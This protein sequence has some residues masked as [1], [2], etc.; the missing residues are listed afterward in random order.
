MRVVQ[1]SDLHLSPTHGFFVANWRKTVA[2]VEALSPDLVIISG[3]LA[4]N[5]PEENDELAFARTEL[6]PLR[7]P[8]RVLPGNHD[9]GD[10]PPGQ[11]AHQIVDAPRLER[12]RAVFQDDWW[13]V[14]TAEWRIVGLNAQLFGSGLADEA[15]Q[16][17]WLDA[18]LSAPDARD[19]AVFLHKPLYVDGI[20][21]AASSACMTPA[22]RRR[23]LDLFARS[24]VRLV[25]SGHLHRYRHERLNTFDLV[26]APATS[27]L[28]DAAVGAHELGI[29]VHEFGAQ[30]WSH[31]FEPMPELTARTLADIKQGRY[32][33]L[34]DMPPFFPADAA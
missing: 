32:A 3:D 14:E 33:F 26:W 8:W 6:E 2:K 22:P 25:A 30:G 31:R 9:I 34:R 24:P 16:A 18:I 20:D 27:F 28:P 4:I 29:V 1:V 7:L 21:D 10:E 11:D 23:L 5:G 17:G 15:Q 12:W 13:M 19:V